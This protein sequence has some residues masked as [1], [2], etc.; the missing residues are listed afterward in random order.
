MLSLK[1]LV[2]IKLNFLLLIIVYSIATYKVL[3]N[4][5]NGG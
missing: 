4:T 5:N 1:K 3:S 2:E